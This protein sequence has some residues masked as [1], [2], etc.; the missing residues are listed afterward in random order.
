MAEAWVAESQKSASPH[1]ASFAMAVAQ[2]T[3]FEEKTTAAA[4][5][6]AGVDS[7]ESTKKR[8]KWWE[9]SKKKNKAPLLF[10]LASSTPVCKEVG[11][12]Q[13]AREEELLLL[14]HLRKIQCS[15]ACA[16]PNAGEEV[17]EESNDGCSQPACS[18]TFFWVL[19]MEKG[20]KCMRIYAYDQVKKFDNQFNKSGFLKKFSNFQMKK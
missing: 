20:Q 7:A 8:Q 6:L 14:L 1:S 2:Q 4:A 3:E 5:A 16:A 17:E 13:R 18:C 15:G 9:D 12:C 11:L 10:A 19:C